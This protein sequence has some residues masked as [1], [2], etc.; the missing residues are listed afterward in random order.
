M[1]GPARKTSSVKIVPIQPAENGTAKD[2]HTF[3]VPKLRETPKTETK[4]QSR[5]IKVPITLTSRQKE[6]PIASSVDKEVPV[7]REVKR[8]P[9][10]GEGHRVRLDKEVQ[11]VPVV[12]EV[13]REVKEAPR[14]VR[15]EIK[16]V[17]VVM[18]DCIEPDIDKV[19]I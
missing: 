3:Q 17:P 10:R 1:S 4:L 19:F 12:R 13:K 5:E 14:D 9:P 11:E 6:A 18:A 16:E 15:R 2:P 8:E 7:L